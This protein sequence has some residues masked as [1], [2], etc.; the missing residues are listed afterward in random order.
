MAHEAAKIAGPNSV[1]TKPI[2]NGLPPD[3]QRKSK[4]TDFNDLH[5]EAGLE[6]VSNSVL[7]TIYHWET[8]K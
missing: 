5:H 6:Y 2:F 1:F 7:A 8:L 4:W 3:V